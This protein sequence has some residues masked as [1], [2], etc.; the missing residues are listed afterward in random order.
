M[1]DVKLWEFGFCYKNK[2]K[3]QVLSFT[4]TLN[5]RRCP[6]AQKLTNFV[7]NVPKSCTLYPLDQTQINFLVKSGQVPCT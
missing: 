4:F 2:S 5:S 7:L 1:K 6:L 3:L